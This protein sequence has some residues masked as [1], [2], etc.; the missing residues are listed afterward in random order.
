[1]TPWISVIVSLALTLLWALRVWY[2][3]R[4]VAELSQ[5][6]GI[7]ERIAVLLDGQ[8]R[9]MEDDVRPKVEKAADLEFRIALDERGIDPDAFRLVLR[10][11]ELLEV[12]PWVVHADG[13]EELLSAFEATLRRADAGGG[14]RG[15]GVEDG[16]SM[17]STRR[18]SARSPTSGP[19]LRAAPA[20]GQLP[21]GSQLPP[22]APSSTVEA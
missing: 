17:T 20:F 8:P 12:A 13:R 18:A 16:A 11:D 3:V 7:Y 22:R 5:P 6:L 19:L 9:P 10:D 15:C 4:H 1:M 14:R 21:Q 2:R